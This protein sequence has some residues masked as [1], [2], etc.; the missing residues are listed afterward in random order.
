MN[1]SAL[2]EVSDLTGRRF[3]ITGGT[4]F[5]GR[6]L[7]DHLCAHAASKTDAFRVTVLSRDPVLFLSRFP[8]YAHHRSL[9]F[10][11]GDLWNLPGLPDGC[12]DVI[13]AAADTHAS[14]HSAIAWMDQLVEGT[15][16]VLDHAVKLEARRFLFVSSGA[17]YGRQTADQATIPEDAA[18]APLTTDPSAVYAQG[19][20]MAETLCTLY[21]AHRG[22]P[23]VIA[24]CFSILSRH[25]P[26][27]GPYAAGNFL[28]DALSSER[29][30]IEIRG[31]GSAIRTYLDGRDVAR[32]L[33]AL[34]RH[35]APGQAYNVGGDQPV[36]IL[37][38][39]TRIGELVAPGKSIV[40]ERTAENTNR[41]IYVPD[42]S[43]SRT[44][45]LQP[46][47][48]LDDA[49]IDAAAAIRQDY[50]RPR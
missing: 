20:R 39:A 47:H 21:S 30:G 12:T 42:V 27:D 37:D 7:L 24:R 36:S 40:V 32:W 45:G 2:P 31:D 10:V 1:S 44:L 6:S 38:L 41:S 28:R 25:L 35:G 19:K 8:Q 11:A 18:Q 13:H 16:R 17:I 29:R 15:R 48:S 22:L 3:F 4:G 5:L 14:P 26:L 46:R 49:I 23:C 34:L 50:G 43:K 9:E 33:F